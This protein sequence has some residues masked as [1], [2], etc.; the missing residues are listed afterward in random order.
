MH[1]DKDADL[2]IMDAPLTFKI[3]NYEPPHTDDYVFLCCALKIA[4]N[5]QTGWPMA[6][7]VGLVPLDQFVCDKDELVKNMMNEAI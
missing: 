4:L 1:A 3:P 5:K 6:S 2:Y 7:N